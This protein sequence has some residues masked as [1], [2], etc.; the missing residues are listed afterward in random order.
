MDTVDTIYARIHEKE[1]VTRMILSEEG[2]INV[3]GLVEIVRFPFGQE[4]IVNEW[5]ENQRG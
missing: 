1:I 4:K 5:V 2:D 3:V